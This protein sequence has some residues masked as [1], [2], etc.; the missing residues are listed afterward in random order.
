MEKDDKKPKQIG[1]KMMQMLAAINRD[2]FDSK[3]L[4][5]YAS[6]WR[7]SISANVR[8]FCHGIRLLSA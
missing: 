7:R 2:N 5:V 6:A 3:I 1:R 8:A 4:L